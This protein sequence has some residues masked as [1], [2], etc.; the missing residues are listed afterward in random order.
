MKNER[1]LI[2][3]DGSNFYFRL[4]DLKLPKYKVTEF[5]FNA[6][7]KWLAR[8]R[9]IKSRNYYIGVI[10]AKQNDEK[11]QK[12][13]MNQQRLFSHLKS[14]DNKFVVVGGYLMKNDGVYHEK[15]VDV[16]MAVDLVVGACEDKYDT[17]I[18]LSSDTDLLPA[19]QYAQKRGKKVEYIGFANKPSFGLIKT[20]NLRR[21]LIAEEIEEFIY[22]KSKK[23]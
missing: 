14:K 7:A 1:L 20:C 17:A 10:R 22:R 8:G 4:K 3:I 9:Q 13:R 15:G 12:L 11:A 23:S 5:D 21:L 2:L 16:R 18:L 19:I 6:F